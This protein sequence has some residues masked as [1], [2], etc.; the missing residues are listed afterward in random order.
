MKCKKC[1]G[2]GWIVKKVPAK[3]VSPMYK[4]ADYELDMAERCDCKEVEEETVEENFR[5]EDI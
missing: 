4:N 1:G 5:W 2:T 3:E